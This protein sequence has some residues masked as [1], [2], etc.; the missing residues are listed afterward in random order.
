MINGGKGT[1]GGGKDSTVGSRPAQTETR[2]AVGD[3]DACIVIGEWSEAL[4]RVDVKKLCATK[5]DDDTKRQ[6]VH[7]LP[8]AISNPGRPATLSR[9]QFKPE[10]LQG[11]AGRAIATSPKN[12]FS[13]SRVFESG[14]WLQLLGG[15]VGFKFQRAGWS[16][17]LHAGPES[18]SVGFVALPMSVMSGQV[19]ALRLPRARPHTGRPA[20]SAPASAA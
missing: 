6:L 2:K 5:T 1:N 15:F 16:G 17:S 10:L 14:Y 20:G 19:S 12:A 18:E 9:L 7:T 3:A 8:H 4:S 11:F 13:S